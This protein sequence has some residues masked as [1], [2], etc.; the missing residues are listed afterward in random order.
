[1][2]YFAKVSSSIVE[3]VICADQDFIDTEYLSTGGP[4]T[5]DEATQSWVA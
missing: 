5:W 3:N 4:Y 1:M 2:T